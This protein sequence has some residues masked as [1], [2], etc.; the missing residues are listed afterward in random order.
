MAHRKRHA[1]NN[2]HQYFALVLDSPRGKGEGGVSKEIGGS[3][4]LP[5]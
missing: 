4:R 3:V 2:C 1:I 5:V